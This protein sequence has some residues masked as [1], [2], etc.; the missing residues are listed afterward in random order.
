MRTCTFMVR[1]GVRCSNDDSCRIPR[2][3]RD[4]KLLLGCEVYIFESCCESRLSFEENTI[5]FFTISCNCNCR[6]F[7]KQACFHLFQLRPVAWFYAEIWLIFLT[8][9]QIIALFLLLIHRFALHCLLSSAEV[10]MKQG[11]PFEFPLLLNE[12]PPAVRN[13]IYWSC[14]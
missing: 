2:N 9:H 6:Y 7:D 14:E 5:F 10:E 1:L 8:F 3:I 12:G 13:L 4:L 11:N